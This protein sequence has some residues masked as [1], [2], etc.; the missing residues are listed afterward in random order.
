MFIENKMPII[1]T[2]QIILWSFASILFA[3]TNGSNFRLKYFPEKIELGMKSIDFIQRRP[4]A[5]EFFLEEIDGKRDG[6]KKTKLKNGK[7]L[8]IEQLKSGSFTSATYLIYNGHLEF[9]NLSARFQLKKDWYLNPDNAIEG[10]L[11]SR[12]NL[13]RILLND[14]L[15][16]FGD[17]YQTEWIK[18]MQS[19]NYR[20]L[21]PRIIWTKNNNVA[22][23]LTFTPEYPG[24]ELF[25]GVCLN[26]G[27]V[28]EETPAT[29]YTKIRQDC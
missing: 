8:F 14:L 16:K 19:D 15:S 24:I 10:L 29:T 3:D 26:I 25:K 20:V 22:I 7:H 11:V 12:R 2:T 1:V 23:A 4:N 28:E 5:K 9:V 27:L 17:K 21:M 13:L 18:V 6:A